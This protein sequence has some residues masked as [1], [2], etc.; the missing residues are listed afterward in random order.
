VAAVQGPA[1]GTPP[2]RRR[3]DA[4][5]AGLTPSRL[6]DTV[7]LLDAQAREAYRRRLG[8]LEDDLEQ[9]RSWADPE[10]AARAEAEIDALVDELARAAGL[11]GR[12]RAAPSPAERARV[13]VTK[14][15]RNALKTIARHSPALG[16]HLA[17]SVHTGRFCSYAPPGEAPPAW[18][19]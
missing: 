8:E 2:D 17:A 7:P 6:D 10:R 16:D 5:Q 13:S 12:D 1:A 11:G 9:A 18:S 15:I 14:A 4:L 19:L 3:S